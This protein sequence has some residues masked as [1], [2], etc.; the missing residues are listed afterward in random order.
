M[1]LQKHEWKCG[2]TKQ[3]QVLQNV[4]KEFYDKIGMWEKSFRPSL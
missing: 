4:L 2:K 3:F 1:K